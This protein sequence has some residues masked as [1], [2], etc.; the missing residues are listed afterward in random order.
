MSVKAAGVTLN[1][2]CVLSPCWAHLR[3]QK[4]CWVLLALCLAKEIG[5]KGRETAEVKVRALGLCPRMGVEAEGL[6]LSLEEGRK[7]KVFSRSVIFD[8]LHLCGV[9]CQ[10]PLCLGFS[11]QEYWSGLPFPS[12]EDLTDTGIESGFCALQVDSLLSESPAKPWELPGRRG[13]ELSS[14]RW[15]SWG[16]LRGRDSFAGRVMTLTKASRRDADRILCLWGFF[17]R[18]YWS[19][20]PCPPP[21][22]LLNPGI[23]ALSL[24]SLALAGGFFTTSAT[25]EA[26]IKGRQ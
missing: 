17:R 7:V 12:M 14:E 5:V 11:R 26:Q 19:G 1:A 20:L 21:G 8:P 9:G 23:E 13:H 24:M 10:A 6:K 22:D 18:E 15:Q 25:W 2:C 4:G 16:W 3:T